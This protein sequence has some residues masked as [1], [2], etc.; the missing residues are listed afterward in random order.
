MDYNLRKITNNE[1]RFLCELLV[2]ASTSFI[3]NLAYLIIGG[4]ESTTN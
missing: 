1:L 3:S 2:W 4:S